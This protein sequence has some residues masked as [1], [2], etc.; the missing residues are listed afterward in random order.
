M[1]IAVEQSADRIRLIAIEM[2]GAFGNEGALPLF[3]SRILRIVA[4]PL[5]RRKH[6]S[7]G[8]RA[9]SLQQRSIR[10]EI[11]H[12][13]I[14]HHRNDGGVGSKLFRQLQSGDDIASG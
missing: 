4:T 9:P 11:F 14:A 8:D 7:Y 6:A 2:K 10:F 3:F 12:S 13:R 5:C 1:I